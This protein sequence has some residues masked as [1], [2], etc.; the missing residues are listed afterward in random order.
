MPDDRCEVVLYTPEHDATFWSLGVGGRAQGRRPLG[1]AQRRARRARRTI[2]Y[3]LVFENRGAEVGATIAHPHGQ[4]YAFDFVP[5]LPLR[6]LERGDD[7]RR[8]RATGSSPTAPGWRA[9]VP[10]APVFP[11]A[12]ALVPDDAR[13]RPAVARR[14]RPRR[15]RARCSST[16]SSGS[17]GSSTHETPYMLWIHQRPFDGGDWP[18]AR[19]HVEIVSPWRAPGRARGSSPPAS[20]APGV[21][22]NPV[23]PEA[24]AQSLREA[25]RCTREAASS[26]SSTPAGGAS[27][28][29]PEL[30]SLNRL[31]P[32]ATLVASRRRRS[33][34]RPRRR[35]GSSALVGRG[36]RT[37][38]A[39]LARRARLGRRST[40]PGLWTMQGYDRPHYTNVADAVR[41]AAAE[42]AG[43]RTRPGIY[44]RRFRVPRGWRR[45][46]DRARLRRRRGRALRARE[47]RSRSGSSKDSRTPAEFDVTELVRHDGPNELV[48]VVVRW[49]DA[50]FVEDQDQWWHAG[51]LARRLPLRTATV[52][53]RRSCAPDARRHA[54]ASTAPARRDGAPPRPARREVL[55]GGATAARRRGARAAAL[56]GGGRRRS[57]RS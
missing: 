13:A 2:E 54:R 38:R 6:E 16:C 1:G 34:A 39:A 23:A 17:T 11:Y 37:R 15:A 44:R 31:P 9:W 10:E 41:R 56:V 5:E 52:A 46:R 8:A 20:S 21:Y 48:A 53:R 19:L 27:W 42:R 25:R 3:V 40:V 32:R 14:R 33:R 4:I 22:F 24:A 51:H 7:A 49:S 18:E 55:R 35:A 57:T 28:E 12:L 50:S 26:R 30:T 43:A 29:S 45:R 47:R 36:P